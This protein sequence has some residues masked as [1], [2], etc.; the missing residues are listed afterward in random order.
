MARSCVRKCFCQVAR[1]PSFYQSSTGARLIPVSDRVVGV[2]GD[3]ERNDEKVSGT[4]RSVL[5]NMLW[6]GMILDAQRDNTKL[7]DLSHQA[8]SHTH[9]CVIKCAQAWATR[10]DC[11]KCACDEVFCV[12]SPS[13]ARHSLMSV[14]KTF[15]N[16]A[17]SPFMI[18]PQVILP[19]VILPLVI[20]PLGVLVSAPSRVLM[21]VSVLPPILWGWWRGRRFRPVSFPMLTHPF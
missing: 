11:E 12:F 16:T 17:N 19:L 3:E 20:S 13:R 4:P 10:Q 2:V 1:L 18:S 9:V 21:F 5:W 6:D 14:R 7:C 15:E 8:L